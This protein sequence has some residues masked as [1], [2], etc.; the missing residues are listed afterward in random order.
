MKVVIQR[1][2]KAKV[3]VENKIVGEIDKGF[4]VLVG[5]THLDTKKDAEYLAKK[6]CNLR[7]FEDEN[8]KMNLSLKDVKGKLLIVSQFTL[9]GNCK[10][11]NRPS[12]TQ[13]GKPDMAEKLY[14]YFCETCKQEYKI[15]V[16][17]GIFGADMQVNLI[18]D[19][20]VTIIIES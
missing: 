20:P 17:K 19:G 10:E 1:V 3:E 14:D 6:V 9:Y 11:G 4:L 2:K 13:A 5:I 15:Q 12:F 18:N 7:I 8:G 16:E